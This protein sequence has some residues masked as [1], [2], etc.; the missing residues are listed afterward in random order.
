[1]EW[2]KD[3]KCFSPKGDKKEPAEACH[4]QYKT[5]SPL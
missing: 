2:L 4:L 3:P 5:S 1:M